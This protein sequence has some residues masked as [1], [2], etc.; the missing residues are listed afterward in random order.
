MTDYVFAPPAPPSLAT[1]GTT[2][3]FPVRRIWCV[4]RNYA[5]HARELGNDEREPPFF[6]SKQPDMLVAGGGAIAY[7]S[8]TGNLHYE[9]ELVVALKAGGADI[10]EDRAAGMIFG[11]AAGLDMTRRDL[12]KQMQEKGKPW[13]IGK[14]FEQSAPIGIITPGNALKAKGAIRLMVNG[15]T[16]QSSDL[17]HMSWNVAEIIA[18]LS[19]QVTLA[20]GDVIFT[21]TPEGVGPVVRGDR[22]RV[23]I[24]GL[25]PLDVSIA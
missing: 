23:E 4:G 15:E 16:K 3:R 7:P 10:P 13:E 1:A 5:A 2:S 9:A 22:L 24:E 6:F 14:S 20:A 25:T 8:L 11:Y 18:R 19:R 21:G 12:Q 17:S